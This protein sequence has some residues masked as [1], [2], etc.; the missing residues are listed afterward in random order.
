MM[1]TTSSP[2]MVLY[3][4]SPWATASTG[5]RLVER[6][7]VRVARG[8]LPRVRRAGRLEI[9]RADGGLEGDLLASL[10]KSHGKRFV[11]DVL[12]GRAACTRAHDGEL[13][14]LLVGEVGRDL[15]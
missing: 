13:V 11:D 4:S 3:V 6:R 9:P 5:G 2:E 12:H 8:V 15:V 10:A 1:A 7:P 14:H